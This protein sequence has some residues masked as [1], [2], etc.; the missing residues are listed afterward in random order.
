MPSGNHRFHLS[1][2]VLLN[3][4]VARCHSKEKTE[5]EH[6]NIRER[7][8]E[9]KV[10]QTLQYWSQK[11]TAYSQVIGSTGVFYKLGTNGKTGLP[12]SAWYH[13]EGH[14]SWT[15]NRK[16]KGSCDTFLRI[17]ERLWCLRENGW[18]QSF[19]QRLEL[20]NWGRNFRAVDIRS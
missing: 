11:N 6:S 14:N 12:Y 2:D 9:A 4:P 16:D 15:W 10:T 19:L 5:R 3:P 1:Q 20:D 18:V 17:L 7:L 13:H 8:R